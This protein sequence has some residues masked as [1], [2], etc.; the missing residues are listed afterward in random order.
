MICSADFAHFASQLAFPAEQIFHRT[1]HWVPLISASFET[2]EKTNHAKMF[3][4][5][6][7]AMLI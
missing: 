2:K 3:S 5:K 7:N 6:R 4:H 1:V